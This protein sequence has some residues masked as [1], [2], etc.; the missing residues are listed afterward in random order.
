MPRRP[1]VLVVFTDQ[2]RHDTVGALNNPV[3]RTPSL[4]RLAREGVA[5]TSAYSPSPVCVP[6]RCSLAYGQYPPNTGCH[7]NR[8][9]MPEDGRETFF[10]TLASA[11]YRT[12]GIGKCHFTPDPHALRGFQTRERQEEIPASP[13]EDDYLTRLHERGFGHIRDPHG[14]RGEMY[15]VPQPAQ[16]PEWLHPTQWIGDRAVGFVEAAR[17]A[18]RPW[19]L[20]VSFI[21][22]HPPFAPPNPWHKLYRAPLM[23]LPKIP[24]DSASL[25]AYVNRHQNRYKYRD[26]G[27]DLNLLRCQK[28]YYY[29]CISFIDYQLGRILDALAE[30]G[31]LDDTLVVFTSD[32]GELLGDYGSFGKR[33]FHDSCAR[34]PLLVRYPERFSAGTTCDRL[35]SLV[36]VAPTALGVAGVPPTHSL[37]GLDLAEVAAGSADRPAV[38][39]QFSDAGTAIYTAV[40]PE[41]KYAYSAPD[42]REYL[43][44]RV[45][46]PAE[47]RNRAGV[48]FCRDDL[49][50]MRGLTLDWLRQS[51]EAAALDGDGFRRYPKLDV[52]DD[53]DAG[54]FHQDQP[55]ATTDIPGYGRA[56]YSAKER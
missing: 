51:G 10:G 32:H 7:D 56:G 35:A 38:F 52:P 47:T 6:A 2:Q 4:D 23:P 43:F 42:D 41:W 19:A 14:I 27:L 16:M 11:G 49:R 9:P 28:A 18:T 3:I 33:S 54:L 39:S 29:A 30:T 53:P 55:W 8:D 15:Y 1:N 50:A 5:F 25:L 31:H 45:G 48:G 17:D 26:Q 20:F 21:H 12:H 40:T 22:P 44:D 36:D 24:P 13:A 34:V 46:D 37:D